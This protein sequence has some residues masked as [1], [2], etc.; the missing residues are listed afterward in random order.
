ML[1]IPFWIGEEAYA[2]ASVDLHAVLPRPRLRSVP[3]GPAGLLGLFEYRGRWTPVLD[4]SLLL[5][6]TPAP[7]SLGTRVLLCRTGQGA[8]GLLCERVTDALAV[9]PLAWSPPGVRL[10]QAPWLGPLQTVSGL[11]VQRLFIQH[12]LTPELAAALTAAEA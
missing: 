4:A 11:T 5:S 1:V 8:L 9:D 3:S 7:S 12:L 2:V 10:E 6:G